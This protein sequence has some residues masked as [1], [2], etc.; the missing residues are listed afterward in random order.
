[1]T[2]LCQITGL[3]RRAGRLSGRRAETIREE[4]KKKEERILLVKEET[5][6]ESG[7]GKSETAGATSSPT[8]RPHWCN[9]RTLYSG[10][11]TYL[12]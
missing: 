7:C 5:E 8:P 3:M 2:E 11:K 9:R 4:S 1:M 6:S 10:G 12:E